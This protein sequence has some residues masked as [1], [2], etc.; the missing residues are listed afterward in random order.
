MTENADLKTGVKTGSRPGTPGELPLSTPP[1]SLHQ[2]PALPK[3]HHDVLHMP[4]RR[5]A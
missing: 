1:S 3:R 2:Q 5:W 4:L